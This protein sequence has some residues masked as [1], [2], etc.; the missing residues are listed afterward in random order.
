M[1]GEPHAAVARRRKSVVLR[2]AACKA[3]VDKAALEYRLDDT[4]ERVMHDAIAEVRGLNESE[5]RL[6]YDEFAP[7]RRLP[8]RDAFESLA[9]DR[10]LR[11]FLRPCENR[12]ISDL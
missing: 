10:E 9:P 3:V 2:L 5:L 6:A 7:R 11:R 1:Y 4:H 8:L 12:H